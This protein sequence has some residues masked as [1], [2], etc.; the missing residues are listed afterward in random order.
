MA[1][2]EILLRMHFCSP[3]C[4]SATAKQL[5]LRNSSVLAERALALSSSVSKSSFLPRRAPH[6]QQQQAQK[7]N[8]S[9]AASTAQATTASPT[10][11]GVSESSPDPVVANVVLPPSSLLPPRGPLDHDGHLLRASLD[12]DLGGYSTQRSLD[13]SLGHARAL[14]SA[15]A[16]DVVTLAVG[17]ARRERALGHVAVDHVDAVDGVLGLVHGGGA[18]GLAVFV[19][20]TTHIHS[21]T[22]ENCLKCAGKRT[23]SGSQSPIEDEEA[24]APHA[25]GS[26]ATASKKLDRGARIAVNGKVTYAKPRKPYDQVVGLARVHTVPSPVNNDR[27][28]VRRKRGI[29]GGLEATVWKWPSAVTTRAD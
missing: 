26:S 15:L 27:E 10:P 17:R 3:D 18:V 1:E 14:R 6:G 20:L 13:Q 24:E 19:T 2:P 16:L 4:L 25:K 28:I 7:P 21:P 29:A 8:S 22:R 11:P 23:C 5:R 12:L 9:I